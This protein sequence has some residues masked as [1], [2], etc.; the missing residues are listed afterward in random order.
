MNVFLSKC[1][2]EAPL[3]GQGWLSP[4]RAAPW[5]CSHP[6]LASFS[7]H[8]SGAKPPERP[9]CGGIQHPISCT[10]PGR[11][12]GRAGEDLVDPTNKCDVIWSQILQIFR[13]KFPIWRRQWKVPVSTMATGSG[14]EAHKWN[15][16][17]VVPCVKFRG[18][19][20][21]GGFAPTLKCLQDQTPRVHLF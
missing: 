17:G 1:C 7:K 11:G 4:H 5:V 14:L 9:Q 16:I 15:L 20:G 6:E 3:H 18:S 2:S 8:F 19:V 10:T 12:A 13:V 21:L